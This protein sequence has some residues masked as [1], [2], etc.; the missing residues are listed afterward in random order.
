M[1]RLL[2][3]KFDGTLELQCISRPHELPSFLRQADT[4]L[5]SSYQHAL[6]GDATTVDPMNAILRVAAD[7]GQLCCFL[8]RGDDRIIAF[9][10][11]VICGDTFWLLSTAFDARHRRHSPGQVLLFRAMRHLH[12][13][14]VRTI[15][16]GFGDARYKQ[17]YGT[18]YRREMTLHLYSRTTPAQIARYQRAFIDGFVS[19]AQSIMGQ[20]R[21][22]NYVRRIWRSHLER[23]ARTDTAGGPRS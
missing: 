16:Y 6:T 11:G 10:K 12:A 18:E 15:D 19:R 20:L 2:S 3:D 5:A 9:Q 17:I 4:I 23:R 22:S 21:L 14:G 7:N 1:D 8:L 13:I